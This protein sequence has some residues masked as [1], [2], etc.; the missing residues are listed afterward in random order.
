MNV[1]AALNL[2]GIPYV[3][4]ALKPCQ[5]GSRCDTIKT[6]VS[7]L[8]IQMLAVFN[9]IFV[10]VVG[11][12]PKPAD[13]RD[14]MIGPFS[15]PVADLNQQRL[16]CVG[17]T[18]AVSPTAFAFEFLWCEEFNF[19][20]KGTICFLRRYARGNSL[21]QSILSFNTGLAIDDQ[22]PES[23]LKFS[24]GLLGQL[25]EYTMISPSIS[26]PKLTVDKRI[27]SDFTW[28]GAENKNSRF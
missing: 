9:T 23:F 22:S 15:G 18:A 12:A 5:C 6:Q 16:D 24:G 14:G 27:L 25:T 7:C 21:P 1:A 11:F 8:S 13:N 26:N 3:L 28:R 17:I 19:V 10:L 2:I 20:P 4:L